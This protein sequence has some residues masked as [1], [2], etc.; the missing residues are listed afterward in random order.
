[1][2]F[3]DLLDRLIEGAALCVLDR[4]A[5]GREADHGLD[6]GEFSSGPRRGEEEADDV[7]SASGFWWRCELEDL[8]D[9]LGA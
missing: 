6:S 9:K 1:M 4:C 3:E 7:L 8:E 5:R 2:E